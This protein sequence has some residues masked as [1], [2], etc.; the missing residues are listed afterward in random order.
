[1]QASNW[2][3]RQSWLLGVLLL[4]GTGVY[5]GQPGLADVERLM[6]EAEELWSQGRPEQALQKCGQ[7]LTRVRQIDERGRE[8]QILDRMGR[9]YL[10][11]DQF[12]QALEH[13]QLGLKVALDLGDRSAQAVQLAAIGETYNLLEQRRQAI[14]TYE[15]LL[16][17]EEERQDVAG[18]WRAYYGL[19]FSHKANDAPSQAV[20][21]IERALELAR[22]LGDQSLELASLQEIEAD[23]AGLGDYAQVARYSEEIV[24]LARV[25]GDRKL[26]AEKLATSGYAYEQVGSLQRA[27]T[28][29]QAALETYRD[30]GDTQGEWRAL[31]DLGRVALNQ[32][33]TAGAV[34]RYQQALHLARQADFQEG[35][36]MALEHTAAAY[37]SA[38]DY[39]KATQSYE[40]ALKAA[41]E[42][43]LREYEWLVLSD[44]GSLL[45]EMGNTKGAVAH[46]QQ[47]LKVARQI[48]DK[49]AEKQL[50]D[51]MA[52]FAK[53]AESDPKPR[54]KR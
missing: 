20:P 30:L 15:S 41:R 40:E 10:E 3:V 25:I 49:D 26:A 13:F 4:L 53:P 47:A 2:R 45:V 17:L 29:Y 51:A 52:Q 35:Q 19:G 12:P 27:T 28:Q 5:G 48:G 8:W 46:Y 44:L 1:M 24:Q 7:A 32:G 36:V 39:G 42:A 22:T 21:Y 23:Y 34:M 9:I 54:R 43:K 18:Q 33:D 38:K 6:R 16:G 37:R 31:D 50:R 14:T 11:G